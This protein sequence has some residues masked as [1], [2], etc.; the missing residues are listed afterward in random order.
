MQKFNYGSLFLAPDSLGYI[1]M[2]VAL[3]IAIVGTV[4]GF[5]FGA[6]RTKNNFEKEKGTLEELKRKIIEQAEE[7]SRAMK[8]EAM[9][10]ELLD[11]LKV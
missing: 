8:K 10:L 5:L 2:G 4:L 7:Q 11:L 6:K 1:L 9:E 3:L